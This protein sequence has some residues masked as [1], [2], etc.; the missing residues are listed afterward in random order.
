VF[1]IL[2]LVYGSRKVTVNVFLHRP[3]VVGRIR[4]H[5]VL[6][7]QL[8]RHQHEGH[9]GREHNNAYDRRDQ[10]LNKR[11]A[12]LAARAFGG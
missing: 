10:H 1:R 6:V 9:H 5:L 3:A 11:E 7:I 12:S 4:D 2:E 8:R